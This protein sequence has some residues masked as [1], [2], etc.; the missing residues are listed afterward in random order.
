MNKY[1]YL[2]GLLIF[3]LAISAC[4]PTPVAEAIPI[5]TVFAA[6]Y[7]AIQAQTAAAMPAT[8]TPTPT[9]INTRKPTITPYPSATHVVLTVT[10]TPSIPPQASATNIT[11]GSG[12]VLYACNILSTSPESGFEVKPKEK[13]KWTLRI[14][15]I[16]TTR[17]TPDTMFLQY[18]RGSQFHLDKRA[19]LGDPTRV[20]DS[21]IFVVK[22]EAPKELGRYT[23]T[24]ALH[25]GIHE[26]CFVQFVIYVKK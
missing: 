11:S 5:E 12:T 9:P 1:Q 23:T 18:V 26:F 4:S 22:M 15:N 21:G 24:W 10:H 2:F 20:G 19:S 3:F 25:K 17:W 6:T 16:G 14:E 13:F 7:A 8:E